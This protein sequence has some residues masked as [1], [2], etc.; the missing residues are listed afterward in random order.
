MVK[1]FGEAAAAGLTGAQA[2]QEQSTANSASAESDRKVF[3]QC[4]RLW[5]AML[6]SRAGDDLGGDLKAKGF[7]RMLGHLSAKE[8]GW[9][10]QMVLDECEWFP[11]VAECKAMIARTDYSNP[12]RRTSPD[13][14]GS[15]PWWQAHRLERAQAAE[16]ATKRL[17]AHKAALIERRDA[18]DD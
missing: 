8:M 11:T 18:S 4:I 1:T 6:P 3:Y 9:L 2:L 14:I 10:T 16:E 5:D 12:F 13:A 17:E 7:H 15:D